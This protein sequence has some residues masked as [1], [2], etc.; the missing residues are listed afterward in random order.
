MTHDLLIIGGG[1][2]GLAAARTAVARGARPL[3]VSESPPGG[4][5]TFTGCVPSKTL[6]EA[7]AR[8]NDFSTGLRRVRGAVARIA[9]TEDETALAGEGIEVLRRRAAFRSP[10]EVEVDGRVL[11]AGRVVIA[12]GSEPRIPP[13]RGLD[14]LDYLTTDTVF[15]LDALPRRL[16]VLGG[17]AVGCE[18]AQAFA[19][20]GA[21]VTVIEE[22]ERLLPGEDAGASRVL[23]DRFKAEGITVR[24]GA[25]VARA[26]QLEGCC[27]LEFDGGEPVDAE[28]VLV[29]VGRN[30]VTA[31]LGLRAA[32]V[33]VDEGGAIRT[34]AYLAT[35]S[36]PGI[37]AAGDVTG[38]SLFTHA[39]HLMGRI[40]T[41]NALRKGR[42]GRFS[43]SSIPRVIFTSP[44]VAQVGP[45]E[46]QAAHTDAD[47]RVA[48]LPISEVDRAIATG[49]TD[50]FVKIVAARRPWLG[51]LGGGR[52]LGA[53]IVGE[54]AGELIHEIALARQ[55]GMFT[56]RLAQTTHAYPTHA[57]AIQQAAAQFFTEYGGR[58][59]HLVRSSAD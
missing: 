23:A 29:A 15:Q 7:A 25:S 41:A 54:R 57:V 2:A 26:R 14:D 47:A 53:T 56:G 17:G 27:R 1:S 35:T 46:E 22:R 50:G 12:T 4:D 36:P 16:A 33:A 21:E 19:R 31:G 32:G 37:Y 49:Q 5:C 34:D 45:T 20:F 30:P 52:V 9:G 28:R 43:A 11:A 40:A 24:T 3:M 48:Y 38:R 8:G 39:A 13:I 42:R 59:A 18:L 44:E 10:R 58:R 6:I 51:N 55:T